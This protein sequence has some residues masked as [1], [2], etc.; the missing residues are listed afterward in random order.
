MKALSN[1]PTS[2][3]R[4]LARP[5]KRVTLSSVA[6]TAL[7][8]LDFNAWEAEGQ[9]LSTINRGS[10]WWIGDWLLYCAN[11]WG[12]RYSEARRITGM[13]PKTLRNI[14]WVAASIEPERR[15]SQLSYSHH[16]LIAGLEIGEQEEWLERAVADR[17][18]VEDLRFE[19]RAA[20][21]GG[22][23]PR[24][25]GADTASASTVVTCP[26]C[27]DAIEVPGE[28]RAQIVAAAEQPRRS[29]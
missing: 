6:W 18:T 19:L 16:E 11:E 2:D 29:P 13:D 12:E 23:S 8:K 10:S 25:S 20:E 9:R 7:Q 3:Q 14:R 5:S 17:M 1:L 24:S 27:G 21:R 22:Y 4:A 15:R 28:V 26:K